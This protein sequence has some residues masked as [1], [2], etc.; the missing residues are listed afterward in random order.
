L[1]FGAETFSFQ[2]LSTGA[3][4]DYSVSESLT[5]SVSAGVAFGGKLAGATLNASVG[6]SPSLAVAVGK[7]LVAPDGWRPFVLLGGSVSGRGGASTEGSFV[8]LDARVS[9]VAG[10]TLWSRLSLYA[11]GRV[12]GGPVFWRG[13]TGGDTSHYQLGGG[14]SLALPAG[15]D[16]QTEVIPLGEQRL[17]GAVGLRF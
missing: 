13:G 17:S 8:G 1:Q 9:L 11:T 7:R 6:P 14:L 5:L 16:L 2:E 15:F 12:F 3:G 10:Y 4:L